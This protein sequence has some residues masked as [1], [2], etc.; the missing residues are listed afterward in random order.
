M[1]VA[2]VGVDGILALDGSCRD[3]RLGLL[4]CSTLPLLFLLRRSVGRLLSFSVDSLN[5][6]GREL[7]F[8]EVALELA[9]IAAETQAAIAVRALV[10]GCLCHN[11]PPMHHEAVKTYTVSSYPNAMR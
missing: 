3:L 10:R 2:Q 6:L 9:G 8:A 5:F 11:S 7:R 1:G 4:G